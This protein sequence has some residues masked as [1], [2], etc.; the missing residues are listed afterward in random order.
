MYIADYLIV[1]IQCLL[2]FILMYGPCVMIRL[3]I[4]YA[5]RAKRWVLGGAA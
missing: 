3:A 2:Y 5:L 1:P 4:R